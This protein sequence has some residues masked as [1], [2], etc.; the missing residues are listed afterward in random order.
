MLLC[1]TGLA[2]SS[3]VAGFGVSLSSVSFLLRGGAGMGRGARGARVGCGAAQREFYGE[4]VLV[5]G[6]PPYRRKSHPHFVQCLPHPDRKYMVLRSA[7]PPTLIF[8]IPCSA[9]P[10][11]TTASHPPSREGI[12]DGHIPYPP[13][14]IDPPP[15]GSLR[16]LVRQ[17]TLATAYYFHT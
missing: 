17:K 12:R 6:S 4:M 9:L 3:P 13:T 2:L 1:H 11:A 10:L 8:S 14:D 7:K 16:T 15:P 5:V